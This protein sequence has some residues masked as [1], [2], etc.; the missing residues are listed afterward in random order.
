MGCREQ[1]LEKRPCWAGIHHAS[2]LEFHPGGA[3][4]SYREH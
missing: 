3:G 2:E 1:E 4:G